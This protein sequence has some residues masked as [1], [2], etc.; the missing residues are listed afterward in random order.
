MALYLLV[1]I[2]HA[3]IQQ[4]SRKMATKE[5]HCAQ[6]QPDP[7]NAMQATVGMAGSEPPVH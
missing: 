2:L 3:D 7:C 1:V 4:R 6:V 5:R